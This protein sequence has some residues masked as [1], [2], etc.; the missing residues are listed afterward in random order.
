MLERE[1]SNIDTTSL[2]VGMTISGG[3]IPG[4]A[5]IASI[6]SLTQLTLSAPDQQQELAQRVN[7]LPLG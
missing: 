1:I 4:G 3:D 2:T 7:H 6:D 5:T